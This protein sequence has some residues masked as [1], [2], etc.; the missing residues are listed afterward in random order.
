MEKKICFLFDKNNDWIFKYFIREK[1]DLKF[2]CEYSFNYERISRFDLVFVLGYMKILGKDFL[3]SNKLVLLVHASDLPYGKGFAP[4]QWQILDKKNK[5]PIV[6]LEMDK[7]VDS[8]SIFL[9]DQI[10]LK[11]NELNDEIREKQAEATFKLIKRFLK[12]YPKIKSYKQKG[13]ETF[14]R[15]RNSFDHKLDIKKS[16][17]EQFNI[18]RISD[19]EKYPAYFEFKNKKYILKIF[20]K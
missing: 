2:K 1:L 20:K 12:K 11:G 8:G 14:F 3:R 17:I 5:I 16:I 4:L 13:K 7:K 18:L 10:I 15:K 6:L 19:N 9:K